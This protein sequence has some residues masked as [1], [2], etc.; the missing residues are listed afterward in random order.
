VSRGG[1]RPTLAEI[2][3]DPV[4]IMAEEHYANKEGKVKW[5]PKVVENIYEE[6]LAKTDF[7]IRKVMLLEFS[8]YL[9]KVCIVEYE[10]LV[11]VP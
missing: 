6:Q 11:A 8:Q 1:H 2:Q 3:A 9:E 7:D 4:S 5:D 10:Q